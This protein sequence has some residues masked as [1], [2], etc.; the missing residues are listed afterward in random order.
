MPLL[1]ITKST[2]SFQPAKRRVSYFGVTRQKHCMNCG[3]P[4]TEETDLY[5]RRFCSVTCK[6]EY[7]SPL[8]RVVQKI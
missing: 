3:K 4:I 6:D 8:K 2:P 1:T 7:C 5:T